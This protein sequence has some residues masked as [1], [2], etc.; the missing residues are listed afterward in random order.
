MLVGLVGIAVGLNVL[1]AVVLKLTADQGSAAKE[2]V[3]LVLA[4]VIAVNL[5][6]IVV[7][8]VVHKRFPLSLSYPLSASFFPCVLVVSWCFDETIG[9]LQI[10]GAALITAGVVM[11][12]MEAR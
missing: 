4:F 3:V 2:I 11:T 7:W 8:G 10:A 6:R 5:C 1:S 9:L 12:A